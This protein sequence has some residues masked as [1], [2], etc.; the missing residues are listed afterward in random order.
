MLA[1]VRRSLGRKLMLA[2][3]LP[4]LL[5]AVVMLLWLRSKT[6]A[7]APEID[8]AYQLAIVA[9][10]LFA[11]GMGAI[12][13]LAMRFLVEHP[14]QRLAAGL[15][16]AREGDFLYRVPVETADE[17]GVLA[18]NF[19]TTL[20]AITDL[21]ARRIDDAASM[22]S[23]QRELALKAQLEARLKELTLLFDLSRRLVSTLELDH[24]LESVTELVGRGLGDHAFALFLVEEGTG[25]LVV[26]NV[27]GLDAAVVG[28]RVRSG[29]GP[30]GWAARERATVLVDDTATD[31]RRP[32]L[33]WQPD[34]WAEGS[35]LSVPLL[36]QSGCGGVLAFFR[37]NRHAFP[38]DE[39]RLLESVAG[40]A[41]IAI[42]NARLHQKMVR[43]SQTDAL[44]G[45]HNRRSL[46]ARLQ[47]EADRC[48]RFD[49][50]MAVALVDVDRFKAYNE[51]HG[52]AA[53]DAILRKVGAILQGTVRKV[54]LVARYG[55]EEFAVLLPRADRAAALAAA[56]KLRTAVSEA[57]IP[58]GDGRVTI[59]IGLGV[60]PDDAPD[61]ATLM[62]AADAALYA[63][64]RAGRDAVRAHEPGMRLH[65][66]RK[67]D[68]TTTA[69]AEAAGN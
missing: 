59:S 63:A 14:L 37:P 47:L 40:Q 49:H 35:I 17:L 58:H 25:D 21:H 62:D 23:M 36:H 6:Q 64:K 65:P 28:A 32:V 50:S 45:V 15:R 54:D 43:L 61:L 68:V 19:N 27:S 8:A 57:A 30:A 5:F 33:P 24:L 26:R 4:S 7:I 42:E 69:D 3:G 9:V 13:A 67:R 53:G 34:A 52:H 18:E 41:A 22:E 12:H 31:A 46:F 56:E 51:A 55:G 16:R 11:A 39:V 48:E 1:S 44:T 38:A 60:W 20:A 66:G 2:I 10:L 29:E